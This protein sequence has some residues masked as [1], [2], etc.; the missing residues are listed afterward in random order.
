M[1]GRRPSCPRDTP[2]ARTACY[3]VPDRSTLCRM[4]MNQAV[5]T[6]ARAALA[7]LQM[8]QSELADATGKSQTYWS[9]RLSGR[10]EFS[11]EDVATF[12]IATGT[13]IADLLSKGAA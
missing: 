4:S 8:K 13:P 10:V 9:K 2:Y 11:V 12:A 1:R 5:A 3:L 6:E 7:R